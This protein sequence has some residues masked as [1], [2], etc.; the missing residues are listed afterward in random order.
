MMD[1]FSALATI[2]SIGF[3]YCNNAN[4]FDLALILSKSLQLFGIGE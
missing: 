3:A 2:S 1:T 4:L